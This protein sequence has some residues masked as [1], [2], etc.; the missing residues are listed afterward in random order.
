MIKNG[1]LYY[2]FDAAQYLARPKT[3]TCHKMGVIARL[4]DVAGSI[5]ARFHLHHSGFGGEV[6]N[7]SSHP[8]S[9]RSGWKKGLAGIGATALVAGTSL[10]GIFAAV[11]APTTFN[12]FDI[13]NGFTVVSQGNAHLNNG[14]IEG[15]IAA[16]GSISSGNNNGYPVIHNSAAGLPDYTVP[17]VDGTSVRI[18]AEEFVGNGSFDVSNRDD[19]NTIDAD[20]PE[21]N[22]VEI[23]RASCR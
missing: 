11:A 16:F 13:N 21:A 14:E 12:P 8:P 2:R 4:G 18:L 5:T 17:T 19:S 6:L 20:S 7:T 22:A 23:G 9:S 10:G 3:A 15:S 1:A